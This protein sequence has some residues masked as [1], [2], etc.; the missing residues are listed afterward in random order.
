MATIMIFGVV[1][2]F[3]G[4]RVDLPI[5]SARYRDSTLPTQSNCFTPPIFLS[6]SNLLS[7]PI[8]MLSHRCCLRNLPEILS[9]ICWVSGPMLEVAELTLLEDYVIICRRL[10]HLDIF[11]RSPAC[12]ALHLFHAWILRIFL[13]NL[14]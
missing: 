11:R 6:F 9:S 2:Y 13:K 5:K 7:F 4:F 3:Q 14:D 1:I 8:F 12:Y 10:K